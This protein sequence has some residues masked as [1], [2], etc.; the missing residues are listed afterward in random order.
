[1]SFRSLTRTPT[2][3]GLGIGA[4][5]VALLAVLAACQ[6]GTNGAES[7]ATESASS[8]T[9]ESQATARKAESSSK[10][11]APDFQLASLTGET[12]QLSD[13]EGKV[14]LIDFWATWCAPCRMEVPHLKE[15]YSRYQE[16]GFEVVGISLDQA[17]PDVVRR[18]VAK[19][20]IPYEVVMGN[21]DVARRYGRVTA[22]PTACLIDRDG[23]V[24]KK[25]VGYR[26][27]ETFVADIEPLM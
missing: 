25:Y 20:E 16:D 3:R 27:L 2:R 14:V 19:H 23:R 6:S 17:G 1:M 24:V 8:V 7:R 4:M 21:P 26:P 22:L 11:V 10:P 18:F 5:F 12:V 9:S 13:Y 15:L